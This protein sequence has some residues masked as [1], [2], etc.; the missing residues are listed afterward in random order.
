MNRLAP[1]IGFTWNEIKKISSRKK[2]FTIQA[3]DK[4]GPVRNIRGGRRG[5]G[6]VKEGFYPYISFNIYIYIYII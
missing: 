1:I 5:W 6:Q 4:R 3:V 2:K